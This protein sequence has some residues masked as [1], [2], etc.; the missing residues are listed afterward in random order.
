MLCKS[1]D[2]HVYLYKLGRIAATWDERMRTEAARQYVYE[3]V[4]IKSRRELDHDEHKA[5][6]YHNLVVEP[7]FA[8]MRQRQQRAN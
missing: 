6:A 4:G 8:F 2:F 7:F 5:Q 3:V 1:R